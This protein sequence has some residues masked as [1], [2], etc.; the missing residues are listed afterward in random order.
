M[1]RLAR[2]SILIVVRHVADRGRQVFGV[3]THLF[4]TTAMCD[5]AD[6][7]NPMELLLTAI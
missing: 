1:P 5:G 3:Y 7:S 4:Y 6:K 2:V